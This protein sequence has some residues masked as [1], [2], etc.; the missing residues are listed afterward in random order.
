MACFVRYF[1]I[2]ITTLAFVTSNVALSA[3]H[4]AKPPHHGISHGAMGSTTKDG[5]KHQHHANQQ[6]VAADSLDADTGSSKHHSDNS[7]SGCC[8]FACGGAVISSH[9]PDFLPSVV[10]SRMPIRVSDS[11][12]ATDLSPYDRPPRPIESL[13][14]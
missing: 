3:V 2:L 6:I 4:A 11:V 14:G 13:T 12:R 9:V 7:A 8:A 10:A 1:V 5:P